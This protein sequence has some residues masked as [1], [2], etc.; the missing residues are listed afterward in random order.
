MRPKINFKLLALLAFALVA[1]TAA[2]SRAFYESIGAKSIGMG[3]AFRALA[4]DNSAIFFN[5]AGLT[6][7]KRYSVGS[8]YTL[9]RT[10]SNNF[11]YFSGSVVDTKTS[12]MGAGIAYIYKQKNRN[13]SQAQG[14]AQEVA[15]ALAQEYIRSFHLGFTTHYLWGKPQNGWRL[16]ASALF[17]PSH[18]IIFGVI[19]KNLV[20]LKNDSREV[21]FSLAS[22]IGDY[23]N[24]DFDF[25]WLPK[26][27]T[28]NL[29]Y[30][31]GIELVAR[32]EFF[33]R[34]GYSFD[35]SHQ[36][37]YGIGI[38]WRFP[39]GSFDYGFR[40]EVGDSDLI[41]QWVEITVTI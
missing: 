25:L 23:V 4:D 12:P 15:V 16:D 21:D 19:G 5:P 41:G 10:N 38:G 40:R 22:R 18:Y 14:E 28:D 11:H 9:L 24:L 27:K 30:N 35:R 7:T 1:L 8:G 17:V 37:W 2:E 6:Q 3:G 29:G 39:R 34:G 13:A 36:D 26:A 20:E 31:M 32:K 33:L